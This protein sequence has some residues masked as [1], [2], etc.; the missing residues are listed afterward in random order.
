L[1][2]LAQ[3]DILY[4]IRDFFCAYWEKSGKNLELGVYEK[5]AFKNTLSL[6]H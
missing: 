3:S 4:G 5:I 2:Q 1:G 6:L